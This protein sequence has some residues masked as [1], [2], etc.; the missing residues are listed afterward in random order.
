MPTYQKSGQG[1][2]IEGMT[3]AAST[4][5]HLVYIHGFQGNDTTFKSFPTDLHKHLAALFPSRLSLKSSVYPTYKSIKPIAVATQNF[6]EWL[7]T[8]PP[9]HVILIGHSMGGLL[10]ADAVTDPSNIRGTR[11]QRIMAMIAFDTPY[12]GMHPH[13]IISGIAS[14]F[15]KQTKQDKEASSHPD[16]DDGMDELN[17]QD[18]VTL[19]GRGVLNSPG[20]NQSDSQDHLTG[21]SI[22]QSS[23]TSSQAPSLFTSEFFQRLTERTSPYIEHTLEH[24]SVRWVQ[25]HRDAPLDAG[26]SWVIEH[27]QFGACM[28][29]PKGLTKRYE[30]LLKWDGLWVNYWT[31]TRPFAK[32]AADGDSGE[33]RDTVAML[34]SPGMSNADSLAES[35]IHEP[36]L[37]S[38]MQRSSPRIGPHTKSEMKAEQQEMKR[39][40]SVQKKAEKELKKQQKK[41]EAEEKK[42]KKRRHFVV[43]PDIMHHATLGAEK[44]EKVEIAGVED[45]VAAHCGLFVPGQNLEY[46]ALIERVGK[47]VLQW[48]DN[49]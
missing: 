25:K 43:L 12:L 1:Y 29:D 2:N 3:Q 24:P 21:Q 4:L 7:S 39:I 45:E 48:C 6:L 47:R 44:W 22:S 11:P 46:S 27:Y 13:V 37:A 26:K 18:R 49:I 28:F 19:V 32:D 20:A 30:D 42:E 40:E 38:D 33:S 23:H 16:R 9:G 35:S 8:Q 31:Y 10:A 5:I 36:P 15:Q 41:Q 14:L 34:Q 17:D